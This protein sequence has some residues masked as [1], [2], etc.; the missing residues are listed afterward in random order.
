MH[1][2]Q[3]PAALFLVAETVATGYV[4]TLARYAPDAVV[5]GIGRRVALDEVNHVQRQID[6]MHLALAPVPAPV[7]SLLRGVWTLAA[8]GAATVLVLDHAASLRAV[9]LTPAGTWLGAMRSFLTASRAA[10]PG[11]LAGLP[12]HRLPGPDDAAAAAADRS[13]R[14]PA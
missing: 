4:E 2:E 14:T 13:A 6:R 8:A 3:R 12:G 1:E 10:A 5:R 11:D 9:G 7:R